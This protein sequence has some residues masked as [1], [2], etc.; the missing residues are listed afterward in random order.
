MMEN[1]VRWE[2]VLRA[3]A[4]VYARVALNNIAREF[5]A[6][7]HHVMQAP[8]DFPHRPRERTPVFYGSFDWHSCVEMH[9][10]LVRLLR[11]VSDQVPGLEIRAA[12]AA[13]FTP[14]GLEAEA[15]FIGHP[16][17]GT[18]ERPYGWGWALRLIH[19]LLDWD[20]LEAQRWATLCAPLAATLTSSFLTWLPKAT[21]P[22]RYGVH[23][24]SAFGLSLALPYARKRAQ[25]GDE[26][27]LEAIAAAGLRW[28]AADTD[29]PGG[30]EP[31]GH[32]FLSPALVEAE[33]MAQLLP[34]DQFAHW[35]ERFL[36]GIAED[37]PIAL[38]T[39]AVVSDS[40]DP[41][42][43]HL[44]GLNACRAWC[45]RRITETLPAGDIRIEHARAAA[46][47][48]AQ[49]AL[50]H[51]AGSDYMVEHWLACYAVLMLS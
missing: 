28:Y 48:H 45:W 14:A 19:E 29:Y 8:E 10:L 27:L 9:W 15:Q 25:A 32:D 49:A 33:F 34:A 24:N 43:A 17:N 38:F 21:Y 41:Y 30:W 6:A 16:A 40:S 4:A 11:C 35:L 2:A 31:S 44:H 37:H 20:D 23:S 42:I 13:Q 22:V 5:P 26:A 1:N 7:V 51:V 47:I 36:P 39:P 18:R 50:P 46:E 12:L 3:N